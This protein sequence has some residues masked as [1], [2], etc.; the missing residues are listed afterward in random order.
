M[1]K[2]Y[3]V[4]RVLAFLLVVVFMYIFLTSTID[5]RHFEAAVTRAYE[6]GNMKKL[7]SLRCEVRDP[8]DKKDLDNSVV[9]EMKDGK[10]VAC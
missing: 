8:K 1:Y 2:L 6:T 4:V 10:K 5:M 9:F 7:K 3:N